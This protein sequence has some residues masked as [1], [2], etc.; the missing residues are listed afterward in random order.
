MV[1]QRMAPG[2][3]AHGLSCWTGPQS[4]AP[5]ASLA[6]APVPSG[7]ESTT[8]CGYTASTEPGAVHAVCQGVASD[9]ATS[10][11]ASRA[12]RTAAP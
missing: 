9:G 11:P 3:G 8:A 5:A 1:R 12:A 4:T 2:A 6:I 7:P 10:T